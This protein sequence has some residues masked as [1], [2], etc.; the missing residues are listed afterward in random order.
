MLDNCEHLIDAAAH[1]SET[2]LRTCPH[3]RIL[4]TSRERL[5]IPG[6]MLFTVSSLA[7]PDPQILPAFAALPHFAAVQLFVERSQA[8]VPNFTL[9]AQN[10]AAVAQICARLDGI[11]LALELA[12]AAL[13]TFSVQEIAKRLDAHF[14]LSTPG[15]RTADVRHQSLNE[16]VAW[17]YNLLAPAEQR[18]LAWLA[19]FVGGWSAEALQTIC[20][21]ET[22][23][24]ALL[25]QLVQKSLVRVA[26]SEAAAESHTRYHLLRAIREYAAARLGEQEEA[27]IIRHH[28]FAYFAQFA[29]ERGADVLGPQHSQAMADLDADYHN[30]RAAF[31]Y[32]EGKAELA[33]MRMRLAAALPY[34]WKIRGYVAEGLAWLQTALADEHLLSLSTR[35]RVYAVLLN[36]KNHFHWNVD[37]TDLDKSARWLAVAETLI[38]PTLAQGDKLA[39]AQLML[40][41]GSNYEY[42]G[43]LPKAT[44]YAKRALHI[45]Q[46]I[47][48]LRGMNFAHN[49][50][51]WITFKQGDVQAAQVLQDEQIRNRQQSGASWGLCEAY[52]MQVEFARNMT[53]R[54]RGIHSLKQLVA[55]AE[56]EERTWFLANAYKD[57][58][59]FDPQ[60]AIKMAEALLARQRQQGPSVMLGVALYQLGHMVLNRQQFERAQDLL[61]EALALWPRLNERPELNML[62]WSL[63][64]RG[65]VAYFLGDPEQALACFGESIERF[66]PSI[67]SFHAARPFTYRG[68]VRLSQNDLGGAVADFCQCLQ[69]V[70]KGLFNMKWLI[71]RSLAGIGEATHRRG[72]L[73]L[74]ALLLATVSSAEAQ[75]LEE[76]TPAL[77][78]EVADFNRIMARVPA[79][80]IS[81]YCVNASAI[82]SFTDSFSPSCQAAANTGSCRYFILFWFISL[83]ASGAPVPSA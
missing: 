69:E 74:A 6:E 23:S 1:T 68:Y 5:N 67:Y 33:D 26:Q 48:D 27:E 35:A 20:Q 60:G 58:E 10:A 9:T 78:H 41:V 73:E 37:I 17:S 25:R 46:T 39:A 43:Q 15:Y 4:V 64:E 32:V 82:A 59:K 63:I 71:N 34:Y 51:I 77:F 30:I 61:D 18:L 72:D 21:D 29:T 57:F 7:F 42:Y 14:L 36:E 54:R 24:L 12:A 70:P 52:V 50:L 40:A 65:Q 55:L 75:K 8:V 66:A 44:A 45:F 22:E 53:D 80:L 47:G 2:L 11:P 16:T 31:F 3:L 28:H 49:L 38:D 76:A 62:P 81:F 83:V 79:Y 19:V 56:Q 13:L